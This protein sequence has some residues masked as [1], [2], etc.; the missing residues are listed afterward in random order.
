MVT[1]SWKLTGNARTNP[2]RHF[3]GTKDNEPL[4]IKT[5]RI[6]AMHIDPAGS[7]GIGTSNPQV[8]LH[9]KGNRIRLESADGSRSLD[10]RADGAALDIESAGAPLYVNGPGQPTFLNPNGG[11]VG[12]G[13]TNPDARLTVEGVGPDFGGTPDAAAIIG[14]VSNPFQDGRG[15]FTAGVRGINDEGHGVQGQSDI[16]IGVE[17]TSNLWIGVWGETRG[18]IGYAGWFQGRVLV[19]GALQKAGGGF[20][21]DHPGDPAE[22]YLNHA[23]VESAEMKNIYDGTVMLDSNGEATVELPRW[24]GV[25]N[26]E[27]RYQLTPIGGSAPSLHIAEEISSN[28]FRIGGG[29]RNMKVSWQVTGKRKDPWARENS[30]PVEQE[31]AE[32]ERGYYLHPE[33]HNQPEEKGLKWS[34]YSHIKRGMKD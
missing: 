24:F 26:E 18:E 21:I 3:L 22:K 4:V 23:F 31:K 2:L 28:R 13:T 10:V 14:R 34:H 33:L 6:E 16:H 27:F 12:I 8:K 20:K 25:L 7:T 32:N 9:V 11:N 15:R 1:S 30:L 17:G 29:S 5:N 19:T